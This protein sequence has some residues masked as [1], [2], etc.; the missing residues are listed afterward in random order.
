MSSPPKAPPPISG[1][2]TGKPLGTG[3]SGGVGAGIMA[4]V[5]QA[6][7]DM[8]DAMHQVGTTAHQN[9]T[10]FLSDIPYFGI[11]PEADKKKSIIPLG[12][13]GRFLEIVDSVTDNDDFNVAGKIAVLKSKLL[14]PA[15]D[16]WSDYT[17][18][19]DWNLAKEHLLSLF[20]EVQSY[21]SVKTNITNMKYE[22]NEQIS[23]Y[24]NRIHKA[25]NTL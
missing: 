6:L 3:P 8:A 13:A 4:D 22:S 9:N 23:S 25:Y 1:P 12:E 16:H 19:D 11:P 7:I 21:A 14:G 24:A 10:Y 15:Q 18:G 5:R 20:P 17:G 2:T